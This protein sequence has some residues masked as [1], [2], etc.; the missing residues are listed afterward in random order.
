METTT[1]NSAEIQRVGNEWHVVVPQAKGRPLKFTCDSL[2]AAERFL[3]VFN[4]PSRG[5]GVHA[6]HQP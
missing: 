2:R 3:G 4:R 5:S 1:T 6:K